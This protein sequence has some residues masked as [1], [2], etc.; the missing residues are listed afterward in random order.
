M[1]IGEL[2]GRVPLLQPARW[3]MLAAFAITGAASL[4][5]GGWR[6]VGLWQFGLLAGSGLFGIALASTTYFAAIYSIGP[7]LT[8]LLFSLTSP[9]ALALGYLVL[10]ETITLKHGEWSADG[11]E[12]AFRTVRPRSSRHLPSASSHQRPSPKWHTIVP[13]GRLHCSHR[14]FARSNRTMSV[15]CCQSIG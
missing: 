14:P 1:F 6:T 13:C 9:F 2:K 11:V 12:G 4:A 8:A 5:L 7:R 3:Q 10:G 15:S